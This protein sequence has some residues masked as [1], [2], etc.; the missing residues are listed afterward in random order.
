MQDLF[1]DSSEA[2]VG[3]PWWMPPRWLGYGI[4]ACWIAILS[5]Q[6]TTPKESTPLVVRDKGSKAKPLNNISQREL[7]AAINITYEQY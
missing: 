3:G 5:L 6:L 2:I 1:P 4:A 7:L